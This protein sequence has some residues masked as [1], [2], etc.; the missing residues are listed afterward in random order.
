MNILF[1]S[2]NFPPETNALS[3]RTYEHAVRWIKAGH[4][5]T[6]LTTVPNSP[7]GIVHKG[8]ENKL[9]QVEYL[10]G[11]KVVRVWSYIAANKGFAKRILD[12]TTFMIMAIWFGFFEKK[13]DVVAGSSPQFFNAVGAWIFGK[14]RRVPFIFELRDIWPAS[15]TAVDAMKEKGWGIRA[16]EKMEMAMYRDA[17]RIVAVTNSFKDYLADKNVDT[18]KVDVVRNGVDLTRYSATSEKPLELATSLNLQNKF[19]IGYLGTHGMAHDLKNVLVAARTVTNPNIH[20]LFVGAGAEKDELMEFAA[21]NELKNVTFLPRQPKDKIAEYWRLCNMALI[22]LKDAPLFAD[23]IP[24]KIFEAMGMGLPVL[25]VQPKGEATQLVEDAQCGVWVEPGNSMGL[26]KKIEELAMQKD[27][28]ASMAQ[29]STDAAPQ[30]SRDY[31]A[32]AMLDSYR[33]AIK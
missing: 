13:P 29:K 17:A 25:H 4:E 8:F 32:K 5:V 1:F 2:D 10:D 15:I 20:F 9:K 16:L 26:A 24:S 18:A 30:F 27:L 23:V 33:K 22:H 11:I 12:Y 19:V 28:L 31:G 21:H 7:E 6:I 14:L 3:S